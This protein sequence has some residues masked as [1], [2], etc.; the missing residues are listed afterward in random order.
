VLASRSQVRHRLDLAEHEADLI[1]AVADRALSRAMG[2][3]E[4]DVVQAILARIGEHPSLAGIRI[5]NS[6]GRILRSSRAEEIGRSLPL[7]QR[8]RSS[9]GVGSVHEVHGGVV[10]VFRPIVNGPSCAGCHA[11]ALPILGFLNA[12]VRVPAANAGGD[13]QWTSTP[14]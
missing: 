1:A 8:P 3:G 7:E 5:V 4:R 11:R 9:L 6:E 14:W 2:L 12:R 10:G 13:R